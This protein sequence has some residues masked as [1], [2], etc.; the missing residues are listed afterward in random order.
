MRPAIT[1]LAIACAAGCSRSAELQH[2]E[3]GALRFDVPGDWQRTDTTA[4]DGVTVV[5]TPR[6]NERKQSVA[7]IYSVQN[8][9]MPGADAATLEHL[10]AGAQAALPH[11]RTSQI[12]AIPSRRGLHGARVDLDFIPAGSSARYRRVHAVLVDPADHAVVHVLYTA[13]TPDLDA[14]NLVLGSI[15]H[16]EG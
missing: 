16:E 8:P 10:L 5:W 6:D 9:A 11:A 7:V 14:L 12:T 15:R 2:I 3:L 1:L 4:R 13:K